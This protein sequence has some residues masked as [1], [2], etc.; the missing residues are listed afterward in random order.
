MRTYNYTAYIEKDAESGFYYGYIPEL[1]GAHTQAATLDELQ[2]NLKEV[3]E[4]CLAS[5]TP[6]ELEAVKANYIGTQQVSVAI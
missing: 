6:D 1:P 4:L 5:L 3:T 2:V